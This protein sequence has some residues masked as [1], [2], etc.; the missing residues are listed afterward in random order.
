[1]SGGSKAAVMPL[2]LAQREHRDKLG[3]NFSKSANASFIRQHGFAGK[4][5]S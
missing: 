2:D 1:M 5:S 3:E 4:I